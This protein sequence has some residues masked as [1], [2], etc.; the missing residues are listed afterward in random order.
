MYIHIIKHFAV[1]LFLQVYTVNLAYFNN[2]F[3]FDNFYNVQ[4]V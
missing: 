1:S 2:L 3:Y 4:N